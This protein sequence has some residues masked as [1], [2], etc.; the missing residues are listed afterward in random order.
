MMMALR[1]ECDPI[2]FCERAWTMYGSAAMAPGRDC[3]GGGRDSS[4]E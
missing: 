2:E 1:Q 3:F 4:S